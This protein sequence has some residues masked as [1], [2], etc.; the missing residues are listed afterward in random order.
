MILLIDHKKN[1][2]GARYER[3]LIF[4]AEPIPHPKRPP[5]LP[6]RPHDAHHLSLRTEGQGP[7]VP[8]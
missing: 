6:V 3:Q 8:F 4:M 5:P 2:L 1:K 7:I